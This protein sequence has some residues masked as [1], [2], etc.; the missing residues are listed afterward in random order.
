MYVCIRKYKQ[1]TYTVT[2]H[3]FW[4]RLLRNR[5]N[6]NNACASF[7][8]VFER[9]FFPLEPEEEEEAEDLFLFLDVLVVAVLVLFDLESVVVVVLC[10]F[11]FV[12]VV[13]CACVCLCVC[14]INIRPIGSDY[15][16]T[17]IYTH[18]HT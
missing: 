13:L 6:C 4:L 18:I 5:A 3:F 14:V 2:L 12:F 7:A 1:S 15:T 10:L 8:L 11:V 16:Y 9:L 17:R